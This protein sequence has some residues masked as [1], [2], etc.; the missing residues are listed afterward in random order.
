MATRRRHRALTGLAIL[1]VVASVL[2]LV[3]CKPTAVPAA[4]GGGSVAP[5]VATG[6][7][8]ATAGPAGGATLAKYKQIQTGM[9]YDEVV[10]IMGTPGSQRNNPNPTADDKA[11]RKPTPR[12]VTVYAWISTTPGNSN[13]MHVTFTNGRVT[14][15]DQ[16]GLP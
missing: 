13:V 3:A 2:L 14:A 8:D 11:P 1:A 10:A 4:D 15:K 5:G 7:V 9:T 12:G 16:A 6:S